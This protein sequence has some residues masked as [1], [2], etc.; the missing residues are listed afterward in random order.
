MRA[1]ALVLSLLLAIPGLTW[2]EWFPPSPLDLP[3]PSEAPGVFSGSTCQARRQAWT[4]RCGPITVTWFAVNGQPA[5]SM[6]YPVVPG[7]LLGD[8]WTTHNII[9]G[10]DPNKPPPWPS[11]EIAGSFI[12]WTCAPGIQTLQVK[13][14]LRWELLQE[15]S[16]R[17]GNRALSDR[18]S[19][20]ALP[21][22]FQWLLTAPEL[23]VCPTDTLNL[24]Q[25]TRNVLLG[26]SVRGQLDELAA[27]FESYLST[28]TPQ[29][30]Q[31]G[32][33]KKESQ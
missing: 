17:R 7:Q 21:G 25:S 16:R 8:M 31:P 15:L 3:S 32:Q 9:G 30:E 18:M 27:L 11:P 29:R 12:V 28:I 1:L 2:A 20:D 5:M 33:L 10:W 26:L 14:P 6:Q 23:N 24:V 4:N 22:F 19:S 13:I